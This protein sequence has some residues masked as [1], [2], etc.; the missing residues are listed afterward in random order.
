MF[1]GKR[2]SNYVPPLSEAEVARQVAEFLARG[3]QVKK[4]DP[5]EAGSGTGLLDQVLVTKKKGDEDDA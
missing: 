1:F 3:G 2:S 4:L 5:A